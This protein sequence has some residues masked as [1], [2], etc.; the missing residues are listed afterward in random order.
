MSEYVRIFL[1]DSDA[2][3]VVLYSLKNL[4]EQLPSNRFMRIHRSYIISLEHIA[5]ASRTSVRLDNDRH[6][7]SATSTGMRSASTWLLAEPGH[8]ADFSLT[9]YVFC[10]Y[11]CE[12]WKKRLKQN[13][14]R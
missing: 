14:Q 10:V 11:V 12:V 4:I 8:F 9:F 5:E 6:F 2:P 3:A 7:L 1:E 13:S